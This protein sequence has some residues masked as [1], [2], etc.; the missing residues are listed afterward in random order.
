M[1][2]MSEQGIGA[3]HASEVDVVTENGLH[4]YIRDRILAEAK[5]L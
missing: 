1:G 4:W 2:I 5:T 3:K